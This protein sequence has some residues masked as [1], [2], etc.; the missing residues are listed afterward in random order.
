M[1]TISPGMRIE[2]RSVE[3]LVK[4]TQTTSS[5]L[6]LIEAVGIS[7]IVKDK[8]IK[9]IQE[10]EKPG[11]V[12]PVDPADVIL[13]PDPSPRYMHTMLTL[14]SQLRY[15][16]PNTHRVSVGNQAAIDALD[17]QLDPARLALGEER[18][19][20]LIADGVGLGKTIEAGILVSELI[21]RGRGQRILVVTT[22]AMLTQFQQEFWIRF[23]IALT[24][25]DS[26]AIQ[27]IKER[28]PERHNPFHLSMEACA[29]SLR[30][31][32][33]T[34]SLPAASLGIQAGSPVTVLRMASGSSSS[35]IRSCL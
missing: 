8:E 24:R 30:S 27:R 10:Y 4:R 2:M 31:V 23:S 19:R 6:H 12:K 1:S 21:A 16:S 20:L 33:L 9:F 29:S 34:S 28:I 3:W 17:F 22:K 25:M 35:M 7:D 13:V 15:T 32:N 11:S 14:E 18:P 26:A 5:K